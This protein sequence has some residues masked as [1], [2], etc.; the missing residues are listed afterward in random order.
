[1]GGQTVTRAQIGTER[2][3][4]RELTG[5]ERF[6]LAQRA[7]EADQAGAEHSHRGYFRARA[8]IVRNDELRRGDEILRVLS[9]SATFP[10]HPQGRLLV[11]AKSIEAGG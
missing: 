8:N 4:V 3:D 2:G 5:R 6:E 1:S 10:E 9:V 11:L 7:Y